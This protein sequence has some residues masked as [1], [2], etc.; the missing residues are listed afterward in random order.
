MKF[1]EVLL[2]GVPLLIIFLGI[3]IAIVF[4]R[5]DRKSK[6]IAAARNER[7]QKVVQLR[8]KG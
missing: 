3:P 2:V 6:A 1:Y 4:W 8:P 7:Q 5:F